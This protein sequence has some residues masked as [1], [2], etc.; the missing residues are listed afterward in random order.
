MLSLSCPS[1]VP[2][3]RNEGNASSASRQLGKPTFI[4]TTMEKKISFPIT[5]HDANIRCPRLPGCSSQSVNKGGVILGGWISSSLPLTFQTVIRQ[6]CSDSRGG[7]LIPKL[8]GVSEKLKPLK[9]FDEMC[10]GF[11][12]FLTLSGVL[13]GSGP[14][15]TGRVCAREPHFTGV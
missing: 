2:G 3:D 1:L 4:P 13:I 15:N 11:Y 10:P 7:K 9:S 8:L 12:L 14:I 5:Q 6:T